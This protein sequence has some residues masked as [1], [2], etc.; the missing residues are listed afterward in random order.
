MPIHRRQQQGFTLVELMVA[1]TLFTIVVLA[2]VSSLYTVNSA[3]RKVQA[4]RT[5]MDNLNF[6]IESMSRTVRTGTALTCGGAGSTSVNC[7]FVSQLGDTQLLVSSTL[8][9]DQLVE[10]AFGYHQNGN[11]AI[12]KRTQ[13]GGVWSDWISLTAPEIDIEKLT[14]YVDGASRTDSAQPSVQLF[15]SGTAA[16]VS[17]VAPFAIQ[18]YISQRAGE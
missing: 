7:P 14:F 9:A 3:S 18:T 17:E 11:G 4:M 15:V 6:A 1:L 8:G 5:V 10:Y 12:K 2:A 16:T 13:T